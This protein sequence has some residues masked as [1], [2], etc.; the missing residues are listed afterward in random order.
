MI[1]NPEN[2]ELKKSINSIMKYIWLLNNCHRVI[3]LKTEQKNWTLNTKLMSGIYIHILFASRH[4]ITVI[5]IFD[6]DEEERG[7][8]YGYCQRIANA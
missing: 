2:L 8:G 3:S 7:D 1:L 5:F 4:V 6:F